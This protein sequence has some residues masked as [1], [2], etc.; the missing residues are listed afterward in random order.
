ML[1]KL[2]DGTECQILL[3]TGA[4]KSLYLNLIT[5]NVSHSILSQNLPQKHREF[6]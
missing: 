6:R 2:L 4:S 3:D 1:G 5:C